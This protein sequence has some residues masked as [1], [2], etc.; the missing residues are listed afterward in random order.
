MWHR[1]ER[2][3]AQLGDDGIEGI[4][5]IKDG[6][7]WVGGEKAV[8]PGFRI[9]PRRIKEGNTREA[10]NGWEKGRGVAVGDLLEERSEFGGW[11]V[12]SRAR[13]GSSDPSEE[14]LRH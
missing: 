11:N 4:G 2:P 14:V 8:A 3:T 12:S 7:R 10:G 6:D 13:R 5:W 1:L 9:D